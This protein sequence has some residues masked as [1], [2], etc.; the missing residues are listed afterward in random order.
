M[1]PRRSRRPSIQP[2]LWWPLL[3]LCWLQS[4]PLSRLANRIIMSAP[5]AGG[6]SADQGSLLGAGILG[7][8]IG[9][10]SDD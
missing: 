2:E 5:A 8:I 7:G 10:G 3:P 6:K 1:C 9:G 4:L